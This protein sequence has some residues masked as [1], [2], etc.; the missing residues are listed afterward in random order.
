MAADMGELYW[1]SLAREIPFRD[2]AISPLGGQAARELRTTPKG[3]LSMCMT[4]SATC[5]R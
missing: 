5:W 2:F 1:M 4:P 3:V